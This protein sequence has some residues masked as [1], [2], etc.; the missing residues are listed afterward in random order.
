MPEPYTDEAVIVAAIASLEAVMQQVLVQLTA[1]RVNA[2]AGRLPLAAV[3]VQEFLSRTD[4]DGGKG[5]PGSIY[6]VHF[7]IDDPAIPPM[8]APIHGHPGWRDPDIKLTWAA[9]LNS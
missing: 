6:G 3:L 5:A 7:M 8:L 1:L 9:Y 4:M 2:D